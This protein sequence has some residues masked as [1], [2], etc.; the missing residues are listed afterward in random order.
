MDEMRGQSRKW[1]D[2]GA[3][4]QMAVAVTSGGGADQHYHPELS[5]K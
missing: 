4:R 5:C 2:G 1:S 3:E